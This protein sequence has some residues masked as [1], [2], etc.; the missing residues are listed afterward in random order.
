M[1]KYIQIN[2]IYPAL[3]GII[4]IDIGLI[5]DFCWRSLRLRLKANWLEAY[6][7]KVYFSVYLARFKY[8]SYR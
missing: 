7:I 1:K 5:F 6:R 4:N 8:D 2:V 3:T